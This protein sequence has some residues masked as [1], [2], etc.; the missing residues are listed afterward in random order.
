MLEQ[1]PSRLFLEWVAY[2][3]IEPFGETRDDLRAGIISAT[4][5][6]VNRD[7]K[8]G[9]PFTPQDFMPNFEPEEEPVEKIPEDEMKQKVLALAQALGARVKKRGE[10]SQS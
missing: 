6:N 2:N 8:K 9:P 4:I 10:R 1:M 3:N 5:A 7:P